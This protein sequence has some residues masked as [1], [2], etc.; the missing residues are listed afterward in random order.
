MQKEYIGRCAHKVDNLHPEDYSQ[1]GFEPDWCPRDKLDPYW[2]EE[3]DNI[4]DSTVPFQK[5][6]FEEA[7]SGLRST[8]ELTLN[9]G[10]DGKL[11]A[12]SWVQAEP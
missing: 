1:L 11:I 9:N 5:E 6:R 3:D 7:L 10:N 12:W 8:Y 2:K 4:F